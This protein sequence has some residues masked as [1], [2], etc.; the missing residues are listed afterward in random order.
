MLFVQ[1]ECSVK[2][3]SSVFAVS[4]LND[5]HADIIYISAIILPLAVQKAY[6]HKIYTLHNISCF[7]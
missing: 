1:G 7:Q 6:F 4:N 2:N 5:S 3:M